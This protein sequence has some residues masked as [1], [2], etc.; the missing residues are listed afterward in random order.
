MP[1]QGAPNASKADAKGLQS[2]N[3]CELALAISM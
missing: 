1:L 3:V 2:D